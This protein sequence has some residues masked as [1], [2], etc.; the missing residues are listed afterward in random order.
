MQINYRP[1]TKADI[2]V[3]PMDCHGSPSDVETRIADLGA[4][5]ILAFEADRH[6]GQLQFRR[7]SPDL[8]SRNGIWHPDYWGDFGD[9]QPDL[10][11]DTVGM[12]CYHVGQLEPGEA[13]DSRYFGR[14]IGVGLV[15]YFLSWAQEL[16]FA[17]IVAKHTPVQRAVMSF[18]GGQPA[19]VY[20]QKGFDVI[21]S[22]IDA[23]LLETVRER[24]LV[25]E[26]T[27]DQDAAQVGLCV[28]HFI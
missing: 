1:M 6:V 23:Q 13:R 10:P 18:M 14:G 2:G 26:E 16:G 8:R 9:D 17:A 5:A 19:S 21:S 25:E 27:P 4:C 20:E 7:H 22:W 24:G 28:R 15:D 3:V 12:F 11:P